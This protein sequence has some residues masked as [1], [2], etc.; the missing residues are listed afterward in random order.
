MLLSFLKLGIVVWQGVSILVPPPSNSTPYPFTN[1]HNVS[2]EQIEMALEPE[3]PIIDPHHHFFYSNPFDLHHSP[4]LLEDLTTDLARGGHNIIKTVFVQCGMLQDPLAEIMA[5]QSIALQ[6]IVK[7]IKTKIAAGIIGTADLLDPN[8][9]ETFHNAIRSSPNFRGVRFRGGNAESIPFDDPNLHR[10]LNTM[11]K[12]GLVLDINGPENHPLDFEHVLGGIANLAR[13]FPSLTVVVDHMGGAVGPVAF[14]GKPEKRQE[15]EAGIADLATCPNVIMKV[16]G[17]HMEKNG[18]PLMF[19]SRAKRLSSEELAILT[20]PYYEN[21]IR[22]FGAQR[23]MFESNFPVD[24]WGVDYDVVW[25]TFKR[26]AA[27]L[28][29]S[30]DEKAAIFHN[31]AAKVYNISVAT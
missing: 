13:A 6:A 27:K 20:L 10:A 30:A 22:T 16:G 26:I 9:E 28:K 21:V 4:Y 23:C 8:V 12:L 18:F 14:N 5:V 1:S 17:L 7:G 11:T 29:L 15:W 25:N 24:K 2:D 31:T 19:S 3:L